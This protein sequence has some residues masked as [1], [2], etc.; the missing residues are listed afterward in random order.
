MN[1]KAIFA[2]VVI[3]GSIATIMIGSSAIPAADATEKVR[4]YPNL[5]GCHE[6]EK[7]EGEPDKCDGRIT[8][9]TDDPPE[10]DGD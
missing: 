1:T 5:N 3:M 6:G 2:I 8:Q 10:E 4:L 9:G 7:D